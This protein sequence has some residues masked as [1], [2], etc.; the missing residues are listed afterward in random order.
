MNGIELDPYIWDP[1]LRALATG[2]LCYISFAMT[3]STDALYVLLGV[4]RAKTYR[5][6]AE[7]GFS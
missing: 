1:F 7:N 6:I 2:L 3:V 5:I 4:L